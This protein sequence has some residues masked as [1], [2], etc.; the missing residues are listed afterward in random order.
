[1]AGAYFDAVASA[2]S[3]S[4]LVSAQPRAFSERDARGDAAVYVLSWPAPPVSLV[5]VC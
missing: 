2:M 3:V 5:Y 1:M 4:A